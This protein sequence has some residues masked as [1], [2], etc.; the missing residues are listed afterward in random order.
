MSTGGLA[1]K[2][3]N[4]F[5]SRW[6]AWQLLRVLTGV[7]ASA[8]TLEPVS[9]GDGFEFGLETPGGAEWHQCKTRSTDAWT[10]RRLS[11][12]GVLEAFK[13]KI[14]SDT[15]VTCKF[16]TDQAASSLGGL[17]DLARRGSGLEAFKIQL[18]ESE[19]RQSDFDTLLVIWEVEPDAA[20]ETLQR[21]EVK[22]LD[23]DTIEDL[24]K[25]LASSVF[26]APARQVLNELEKL[27]LE[28]LTKRI[29]TDTAR[30]LLRDEAGFLFRDYALNP[31]VNTRV[32]EATEHFLDQLA[33][34]LP[35]IQIRRPGLVAEVMDWYGDDDHSHLLM[36]GSAGAGKSQL[37]SDIVREFG[38]QGI[39]TLPIRLDNYLDCKSMSELGASIFNEPC[40]PVAVLHS[41]ARQGPKPVLVLDQLDA[42]SEISGR[43]GALK[44]LSLRLTNLRS[45]D[46][47]FKVIIS[48]RSYDL[49]ND[50][51][52]ENLSKRKTTRQLNVPIFSWEDDLKSAFESAGIP[53]TRFSSGL[54]RLLETPSNLATFMRLDLEDK[55]AFE[56]STA[57]GLVDLL[58][59]KTDRDLGKLGISW[60]CCEALGVLVDYMNEHQVLIA[61]TAL[62]KSYNRAVDLL[63]S[64][65]LITEQGANVRLAH[66]SYFDHLFASRFASA[67]RR[68]LDWLISSEQHLFRRTQVRQ[69]LSF[70]RAENPTSER[71]LKTIDGALNGDGIRYLVKDSA[72]RWLSGVATPTQKEFEIVSRIDQANYPSLLRRQILSGK[73]WFPVLVSNGHIQSWL[74]SVDERQV[75]LAV[76]WTAGAFRDHPEIAFEEIE[77]FWKAAVNPLPILQRIFGRAAPGKNA[78]P[79][80][81]FGRRL[82]N[83]PEVEI[84]IEE[85]EVAGDFLYWSDDKS[86]YGVELTALKHQRYMR[87]NPACDLFVGNGMQE[88]KTSY[89]IQ[90]LAKSSPAAFVT[91]F[92]PLYAET[93]GRIAR[94]ETGHDGWHAE[95]MWTKSFPEEERWGGLL[96]KTLRAAQEI[97]P[98]MCSRFIEN[99]PVVRSRMDLFFVLSAIGI[100]GRDCEVAFESC[101]DQTLFFDADDDG[102]VWMPAAEAA[103][104]IRARVSNRVWAKFEEKLF[105]YRPEHARARQFVEWSKE[106]KDATNSSSERRYALDKLT[107]TGLT[108]WRIIQHIGEDKFTPERS[109]QIQELNRKFSKVFLQREEKHPG[110]WVRPPISPE[111]AEHMSNA[112]WLNAIRKFDGDRTEFT[113][114]GPIGNANAL[115][116]VFQKCVVEDPVRFTRLFS[117]IGE[118][119]HP[120]YA[121]AILYGLRDSNANIETLEQGIL[122]AWPYQQRYFDSALIG[123]LERHPAASGNDRIFAWTLDK[124]LNGDPPDRTNDTAEGDLIGS[125]TL[126]DLLERGSR[127]FF[128]PGGANRNAAWLVLSKVV[129]A[130]PNR[131]MVIK[132]TLQAR[133]L[134]EDCSDVLPGMACACAA[135]AEEDRDWVFSFLEDILRKDIRVFANYQ[136]EHIFGWLVWQDRNRFRWI[137]DALT[138][139]DAEA[140]IALGWIYRH[141]MYFAEHGNWYEPSDEPVLARRAKAMLIANRLFEIEPVRHTLQ[142]AISLLQDESADV[143][144]QIFQAGWK[145]AL[146]RGEDYLELVSA[147][148]DAPAFSKHGNLLF[149]A[150]SD[151]ARSYPDLGM[152]MA[153]RVLEL[154]ESAEKSPDGEKL[155]HAFWGLGK[156]VFAVCE[157]YAER[158]TEHSRALDLVDRFLAAGEYK[159]RS[160]A[161]AFDRR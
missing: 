27:S 141:N 86:G 148:I 52:F 119:V 12:A 110:G 75:S 89:L 42:V 35:D 152:K 4:K 115:A 26:S 131:A 147:A 153:H 134:D 111:Q 100:N 8:I 72:A 36:T 77:R 85:S 23:T 2:L 9:G 81:E 146:E 120:A 65:G 113:E 99:F 139:S 31:T 117:E 84:Q 55:R 151:D 13:N 95:R 79:L 73:D 137:L 87:D 22:V 92:A 98:D 136:S 25:E 157:A 67:G 88:N 128:V 17:C 101:L 112:A 80:A 53:T 103:K 10:I 121:D 69:I 118:T 145:T 64:A 33:S 21:I 123:L 20:W 159:F 96:L 48:C 155:S 43:L 49:E 144:K 94:G 6:V 129:E 47:P 156:V 51:A 126:D 66:E 124:A 104:S 78:K 74:N 34:V 82:I 127:S 24:I 18:E 150:L 56:V 63:Q 7:E 58:I 106:S 39:P 32:E 41:L 109:R 15:N 71:Y 14:H 116:D 107:T 54:T 90:E 3:G 125:R 38:S 70:L 161:E 28:H 108:Q 105:Q 46:A 140:L 143:G 97:E 60:G 61:P 62:I 130:V 1:D 154:T 29:D 40:D 57:G 102:E 37:L 76:G 11:S 16:V 91:A 93:L 30:R 122:A 5:E 132:A 149:Y 158:G 114:T 59:R 45:G 138:Q 135:F 83:H 142:T 44:Q 50:I 160:E 68:V 133:I 19:K